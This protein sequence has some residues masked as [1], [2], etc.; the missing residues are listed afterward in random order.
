MEANRKQCRCPACNK[1]HS[2]GMFG[3]HHADRRNDCELCNGTKLVD[4]DV[5]KRYLVAI[6]SLANS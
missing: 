3:R 1:I 6:G 2:G 4:I 5:A